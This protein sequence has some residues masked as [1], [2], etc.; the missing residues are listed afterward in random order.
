MKAREAVYAAVG[1]PI[2]T[3]R[4]LNARLENLRDEFETR[5]EGLSE[6]AQQILEEW[7]T[8]GRQ[9]VERVS[10]GRVVDEFAAKVDFDQAREQVGKL[11]EQLEDMLAT[12]RASF[13]PETSQEPTARP[14]TGAHPQEAQ[15]GDVETAP[16]GEASDMSGSETP[17]ESPDTGGQARPGA[18]GDETPSA[19]EEN[20]AESSDTE[21]EGE[22]RDRIS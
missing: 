14:V 15:T 13:R 17:P 21:S 2:V 10:D 8:E 19:Q 18:A 5:S 4:A 7:T 3:A 20:R 12:W 9:T 6:R 1:A 22:E 16:T 11:R